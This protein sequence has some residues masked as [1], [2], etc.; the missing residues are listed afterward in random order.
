MNRLRA[1]FKTYIIS[2]KLVIMKEFVCSLGTAI[3]DICYVCS[4]LTTVGILARNSTTVV[5][6]DQI[7]M[8]LHT[9]VHNDFT[10]DYVCAPRTGMQTDP[11]S[12]P[13]SPPPVQILCTSMSYS[14]SCNLHHAYIDLILLRTSSHIALLLLRITNRAREFVCSYK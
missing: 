7:Y 13:V 6:P 1:A 11:R 10:H 2:E 4:S 3:D 12:P 14:V 5:P 9:D 8:S